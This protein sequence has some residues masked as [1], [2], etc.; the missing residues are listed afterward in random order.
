MN[1]TIPIFVINLKKDVDKRKHM[2]DLCKQHNLEC[3]FV[4]AV[5]GKDL[6]NDAIVKIYN[7][8]EALSFY[9]R[10]LTR[11][12]I[13]CALSHLNIY[14]IMIENQI[15]QAIIFEDDIHINNGFLSVIQSIDTF[16]NDWELI[17]LGHLFKKNSIYLRYKQQINSENYIMR[18]CDVALGTHA[19]L[20]NLKGAL[21]L[22]NHLN[23][24]KQPI[25]HF[26][27]DEKYINLYGVMP[28]IVEVDKV[29][30]QDSNIAA[31]RAQMV[32][33]RL[34]VYK[35]LI[36]E[37]FIRPFRQY[38]KPFLKPSKYN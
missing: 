35:K 4:D 8:D 38:I 31:E 11:G 36:R 9:K 15:K 6:D 21:K 10:E 29:L 22:V 14:K 25:D 19:Y 7:P 33:L 32:V 13:G 16:P 18:F 37:L 34:P 27:G 28:Q 2:E 24:I 23:S 12:E 5:Y 17:L 26:T 20:I 3:Q 1:I 30:L